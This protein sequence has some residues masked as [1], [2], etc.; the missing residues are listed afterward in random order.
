RSPSERADGARCRPIM[1][2]R[3]TVTGSTLRP[4]TVAQKAEIAHAL[5][6]EVWPWLE[7]G[8]IRPVIHARFGLEQ[9]RE[10]HELME[11]SVHQG[12]IM[13]VTGR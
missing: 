3:L 2:K 5:Q 7:A 12:K 10:A 6:R 1:M 8:S 4:R 11:S 13:L 9:A